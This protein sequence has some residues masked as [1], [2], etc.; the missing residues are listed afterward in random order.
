[1]ETSMLGS[2]A[3]SPAGLFRRPIEIYAGV[4]APGIAIF[5]DLV[6]DFS[7]DKLRESPEHVRES[8][9]FQR[10]RSAEDAP[11]TPV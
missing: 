8:I 5:L 3:Q 1:M 10:K 2:L 4:D 11:L 7:L 6:T 9:C